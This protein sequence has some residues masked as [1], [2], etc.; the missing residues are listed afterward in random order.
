M[1]GCV[2][3]TPSVDNS[4]NR[5]MTAMDK[6]FEAKYPN[7]YRDYQEKREAAA[8]TLGDPNQRKVESRRSSFSQFEKTEGAK[9]IP[10]VLE[11]K[12][13]AERDK[14]MAWGRANPWDKAHQKS[15]RNSM[16]GGDE[17]A[18]QRQQRR[19]SLS[20]GSDS[21]PVKAAK[22]RNSFS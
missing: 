11:Q 7:Q 4:K 18:S 20:L 6:Y 9:H 13:M 5:R 8:G 19:N 2:K 17:T 14:A 1:C 15:R 21:S 3:T 10:G 12:A 16:V 22:R